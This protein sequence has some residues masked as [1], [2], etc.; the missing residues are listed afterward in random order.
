MFSE[1]NLSLKSEYNPKRQKIEAVK[2]TKLY[3]LYSLLLRITLAT[4]C[5]LSRPPRRSTTPSRRTSLRT[6]NVFRPW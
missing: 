4:T 3:S 6:R 5:R 2:Y 1:L